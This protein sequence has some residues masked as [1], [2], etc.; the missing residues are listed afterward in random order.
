[1]GS[2]NCTTCSAPRRNNSIFAEDTKALL[3]VRRFQSSEVQVSPPAVPVQRRVSVLGPGCGAGATGRW[4]ARVDVMCVQDSAGTDR[5]RTSF[6][7]TVV[8]QRFLP[9]ALLAQ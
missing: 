4:S 3:T 1:M 5:F 9:V 7:S 8:C 2:I 6:P